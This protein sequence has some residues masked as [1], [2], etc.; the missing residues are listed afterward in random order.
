MGITSTTNG[1]PQVQ[2]DNANHR[3]D[4]ILHACDCELGKDCL[5]GPGWQLLTGILCRLSGA[6]SILPNTL[7]HFSLGTISRNLPSMCTFSPVFSISW[8]SIHVGYTPSPR[9]YSTTNMIFESPNLH[10]PECDN[11]WNLTRV[12]LLLGLHYE[13]WVGF[14]TDRVWDPR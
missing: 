11:G 4:R 6:G 3:L 2:M 14:G 5:V 13:R 9:S 12:L 7:V 1:F 8:A 10:R